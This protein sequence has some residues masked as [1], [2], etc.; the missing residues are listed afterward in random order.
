MDKFMKETVMSKPDFTIDT[1]T[2]NVYYHIPG[3]KSYTLRHDGAVCY[4]SNGFC[5]DI[6]RN[7]SD[8]IFTDFNEC[9]K[10]LEFFGCQH[11]AA[12]EYPDEFYIG[13]IAENNKAFNDLIDYACKED[14][15]MPARVIITPECKAKGDV[16]L[17]R[18]LIMKGVA[19]NLDEIEKDKITVGCNGAQVLKGIEELPDFYRVTGGPVQELLQITM[20]EPSISYNKNNK[21]IRWAIAPMDIDHAKY[22]MNYQ[23]NSVDQVVF[24]LKIFGA[25]DVMSYSEEFTYDHPS[26]GGKKTY[27][28]DYVRYFD[29]D[30]NEII[31]ICRKMHGKNVGDIILDIAEII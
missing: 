5:T 1:G 25:K 26:Y 21:V 20:A 22:V 28:R 11:G 3:V 31:L 12:L 2:G 23:F 8:A 29:K 15:A 4:M 30:D 13:G 27:T 16:T 17:Y 18:P 19:F 6:V 9:C 7:L 10:F 14:V 24:C